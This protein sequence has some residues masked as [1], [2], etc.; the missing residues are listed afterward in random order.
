[1]ERTG[2]LVRNGLVVNRIVWADHTA[3]QLANDGYDHMEETTSLEDPPGIGWSWSTTDGYRR[4]K[5]EP[6]WV[7]TGI[8]WEP[9]IPYPTDGKTYLWD[10]P[11][12]RWDEVPAPDPE[13]S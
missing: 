1:M 6:S 4:P 10:E 9:P 13:I 12:L 5:P 11:N 7:W 3:E 8:I 2:V